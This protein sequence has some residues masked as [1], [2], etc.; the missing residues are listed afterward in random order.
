MEKNICKWYYVCPI[1]DF[2][3]QGKLDKKW[4]ENYCFRGGKNCKRYRMEEK[5]IAHPDNML[6]DG[7]IDESL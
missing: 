1:V 7:T 5:G 2:V 6:P 4:V 3:R